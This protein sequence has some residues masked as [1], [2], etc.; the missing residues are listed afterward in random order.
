MAQNTRIDRIV[1][2]TKRLDTREILAY[3]VAD[4]A[5]AYGIFPHALDHCN[6]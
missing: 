3:D 2:H 1:V 4:P 5:N 6:S